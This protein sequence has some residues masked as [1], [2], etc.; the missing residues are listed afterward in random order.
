MRRPPSLFAV[1]GKLT[2]LT[3]LALLTMLFS[4]DTAHGQS[5]CPPPTDLGVLNDLLTATGDWSDDECDQSRFQE[6]RPG[7]L[8]LFS[9]AEDAEVRIDLSSPERDTVVY[10]LDQNGRLIDTDDDTGGGVN[11][12]I[13][14]LL[15]AGAYQI[16]ASTIGWSGR[17]IGTF[18]VALRI[19]A[20]CQDVVDLGVLEDSLSIDAAWK[21]F[22]CESEFRPDRS[23]QQYRFEVA[24]RANVQIDLTSI[25]ADPYVYLLDETGVLLEGDDDDGL[26]FN[27]RITRLLDIGTYTIEATNWGDRDLKNLQDAPYQLSIGI[28]ETGPIIKLE[29]IDAPDR[30]VL[31]MPFDIHYR[32]GNLGDAPLA[33]INGSVQIRLR[34]PYVSNW[35]TP[36]VGIGDGEVPR[37][38]VG[39]SYHTSESLSAFGSESL[40][41]FQPFD[42]SFSWRYGPT[43]VMLEAQVFDDN[44]DRIDRHWLTRPIMVLSGIEFDSVTVSV[45]DIEYHV[46]AIADEGGEVTTS[47]TP[48]ATGEDDSPPVDEGGDDSTDESADGEET[49][50]DDQEVEPEIS[51]RA[52]YAAGVRT[53]VLADLSSAL[54]SLQA[55][56]DSLYSQVQRGGLP[57][58]DQP[59]PTAPTQEALVDLLSAV[60]RETLDDSGFDLQ[61]FQSAEA[62]EQIVVRHG[63]A[64]AR[65]IEQF[66][67]NWARLSETDRVITAGEALQIHAELA[68]AQHV[69]AVLVDA[70]MLVLMKRDAEPG[71]SDPAVAAA[72]DAFAAGADCDVDSGALSLGDDALRELSPIYGFALDRAYCGAVEASSD[73]DLLLTGLGLDS[74]PMIPAPEVDEEPPVPA[75]VVGVRLLARVLDDGQVEFAVDL[76]NGD[77]A[78]PLRRML[79]RAATADQWLRTA[80]VMLDAEQLGRIYAR[81]LSDG[82]VQATYV[83]AG[84][85]MDSTPRWVVP[86]GAPVNAWLVSGELES[87]P[88]TL[89]D[90]LVQRVGDQAAGAGPAQ[91][92]DHLSLLSLIENDLQRNP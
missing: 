78:L 62:A 12:R 79:P 53:Q 22:G 65:R 72:L 75:P 77:R 31:G 26:R 47:V 85:G 38:G 43:D 54:N 89:R 8:F 82:L 40:P 66:N 29:A 2:A 86:D 74:N 83:P 58:S 23:S 5:E 1:S 50:N 68:F 7:R 59:N 90:D 55:L 45:D 24:Q 19:V 88:A 20:D 3:V 61:E 28:V 18:E 76:S 9:L 32:V 11:A 52:M 56:A 27:S 70:A 60:H 51:A 73:H 4:W 57:I 46:A 64:A 37:W 16:E 13:E 48:A 17:E 92:G 44:D 21:H 84:V 49:I 6:K 14:R 67:R 63:R 41:Q 33:A 42:A 34:W 25:T 87:G 71:W 80:P 15:P 10:L 69:D 36:I 39:A 91:F 35:R 81:R 30:V